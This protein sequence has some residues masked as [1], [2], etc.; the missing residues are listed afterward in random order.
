MLTE[1]VNRDVDLRKLLFGSTDPG[2]YAVFKTSSNPSTKVVTDSRIDD[3]GVSIKQPNS[4][5]PLL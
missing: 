3:T 2:F 1:I 4:P 5:G